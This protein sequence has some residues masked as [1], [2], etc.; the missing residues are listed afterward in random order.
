MTK[1]TERKSKTAEPPKARKLAL[2]RDTLKDLA[3]PPRRDQRVKGGANTRGCSG[4]TNM[5]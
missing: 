3:A 1:K 5:T 2:T 4:G